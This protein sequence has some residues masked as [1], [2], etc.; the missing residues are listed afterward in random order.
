VP[1]GTKRIG[2]ISYPVDMKTGEITNIGN[3]MVSI[4]SDDGQNNK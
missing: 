3:V 1:K 4:N 2:F